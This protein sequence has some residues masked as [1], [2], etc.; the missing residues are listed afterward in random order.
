MSATPETFRF[1]DWFQDANLPESAADIFTN[2][3]VLGDLTDLQHRIEE[4]SAVVEAEP[5]VG[6]KSTLRKLEAEY[7]ALAEQFMSSKITVYVR[8]LTATERV[9]VRAE[10]DKAKEANEEFI[11]RILA[12]SIIG[13]KKPEGERVAATLT[14]DELRNLYSRIGDTQLTAIYNA[15]LTA[16]NAM[17]TVDA[18]FLRKLSGPANG[19]E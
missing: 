5:T 7:K 17:P 1:D 9:A 13:M 8:A 15:Q 14:V 16:T 18:D 10:H 4:E 12:L 2:S 19:P 6:A 3:A 11:F